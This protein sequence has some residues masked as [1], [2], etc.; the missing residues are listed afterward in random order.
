MQRSAPLGRSPILGFPLRVEHQIIGSFFQELFAF[1]QDLR[2]LLFQVGEL[3]DELG[4]FF[5]LFSKL[6]GDRGWSRFGWWWR[7]WCRERRRRR[8]H[9]VVHCRLLRLFCGTA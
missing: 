4:D 9:V 5:D 1:I 8:A 2:F 7:G 3:V 6:A